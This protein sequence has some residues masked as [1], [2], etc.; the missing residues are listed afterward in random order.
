MRGELGIICN[1]SIVILIS[2]L[3]TYNFFTSSLR[4]LEFSLYVLI[5]TDVVSITATDW[6]SS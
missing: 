2:T 1:I 6:L 3:L 4:I 5:I